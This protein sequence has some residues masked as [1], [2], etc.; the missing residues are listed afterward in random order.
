MLADL[1][2]LFIPFALGIG[3]FSLV[4]RAAKKRE[5]YCG[6]DPNNCFVCDRDCTYY[7]LKKVA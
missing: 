2:P 5:G 1:F 4:L 3:M 7:D 6:K